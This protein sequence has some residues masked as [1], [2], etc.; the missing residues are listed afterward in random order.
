MIVSS[1]NDKDLRAKNSDSEEEKVTSTR[2]PK[3]KGNKK[4]QEIGDA[5]K[6]PE[7]KRPRGRPKKE[8][9][10]ENY[11]FTNHVMIGTSSRGKHL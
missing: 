2:E 10:F 7:I 11:S 9:R 4:K 5:T 1:T 8:A 3:V 6:T